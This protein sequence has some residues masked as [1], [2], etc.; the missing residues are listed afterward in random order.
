MA[1]TVMNWPTK[2]SRAGG[3]ALV[4]YGLAWAGYHAPS[5]GNLGSFDHMNRFMDIMGTF[6]AILSLLA[7]VIILFFYKLTDEQAAMYAKANAEREAA[8]AAAEK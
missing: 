5:A 7:F 1:V 4:G 8:E 6:P 2:I 3:G